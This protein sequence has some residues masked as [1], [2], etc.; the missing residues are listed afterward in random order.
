M[1]YN[2]KGTEVTI[3]D[4]LRSYVESRLAQT[5]KFL[6]DDS[7]AHCDVELAYEAV[8]DGH[9]YRAEFTVSSRGEVYRA[10]EWGSALHEA[11]DLAMA[12]LMQELRRNKE[13]RLDIVRRGAAKAKNMLRFWR[14]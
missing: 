4:E 10:S 14:A 9:K 3:T 6:G 7:T 12:E 2:I 8:R 5:D 11:I 13:K 1:N